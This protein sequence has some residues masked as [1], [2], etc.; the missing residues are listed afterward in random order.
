MSRSDPPAGD[1]TDAWEANAAW[2]QDNFTEGADP[3]Y[4][5]QI[6]P[7]VDEHLAGACRI[8]DVGLR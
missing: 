3:E 5:E 6:L 8:L 1:P 2:W 4:E 7:L